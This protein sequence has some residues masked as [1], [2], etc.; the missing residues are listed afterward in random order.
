MGFKQSSL[1]KRVF[2]IFKNATLACKNRFYKLKIEF[3]FNQQGLKSK[4]TIEKI[5]FLRSPSHVCQSKSIF[6][7]KTVNDVNA[8]NEL[9]YDHIIW[10][11][12]TRQAE[13]VL[14]NPICQN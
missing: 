14:H 9:V 2:I 7:E 8:E 3:Q 10:K 4:D 6:I 13:R 1:P 5:I 12:F 11:N